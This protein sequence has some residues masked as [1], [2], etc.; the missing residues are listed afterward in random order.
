[1]IGNA[2]MVCRYIEINEKGI[3][4]LSMG[5]TSIVITLVSVIVGYAVFGRKDIL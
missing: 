5:I 4:L 1:M 3:S 2:F